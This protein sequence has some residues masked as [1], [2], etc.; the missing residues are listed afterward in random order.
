M[1]RPTSVSGWRTSAIDWHR[2]I[3]ITIPQEKR[4]GITYSSPK[5]HVCPVATFQHKS[6]SSRTLPNLRPLFAPLWAFFCSLVN[7]VREGPP[8]PP[9]LPDG[10][11]WSPARETPLGPLPSAASSSGTGLGSSGIKY[12]VVIQLR[13]RRESSIMQART[14]P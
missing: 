5:S 13:I 4:G 8:P 7:F 3:S 11:P 10:S 2:S 9:A 12:L 1:A 14:R 6:C